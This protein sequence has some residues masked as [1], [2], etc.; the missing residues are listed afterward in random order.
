MN[1]FMKIMA[2]VALLWS[3]SAGASIFSYITES[4]GTPSNAVYTYIIERWDPED[5]SA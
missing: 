3:A 2:A 4:S 1:R 5:P